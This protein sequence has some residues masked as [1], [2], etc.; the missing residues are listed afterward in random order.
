MALCR[1]RPSHI[2]DDD[3]TPA[4][5][6]DDNLAIS[7]DDGEKDDTTIECSTDTN[8]GGTAFKWMVSLTRIVSEI[9]RKF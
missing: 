8:A 5:L 1:G 4:E 9:L 7:Q 3:W 2:V 6:T